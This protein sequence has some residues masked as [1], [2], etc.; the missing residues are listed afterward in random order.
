VAKSAGASAVRNLLGVVVGI[1]VVV[2]LV[3]LTRL[4]VEF[5]GALH[6]GPFYAQLK[7][8]T[9]YVVL[10]LPVAGFKTPYGGTFDVR[11]ALS[12]VIYL[13]AEY[14]LTALRRRV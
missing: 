2:M 7:A 6:T 12:I 13:I 8:I 4:I 10:P 5:F 14:L 11:A 3:L 1:F 9:R